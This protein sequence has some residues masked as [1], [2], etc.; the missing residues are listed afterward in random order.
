M[1]AS[2]TILKAVGAIVA[3]PLAF[4]W[5]KL[6]NAQNL[7]PGLTNPKYERP[8]KM[9]TWWWKPGDEWEFAAVFGKADERNFATPT[10]PVAHYC[11]WGEVLSDGDLRILELFFTPSVSRDSIILRDFGKLLRYTPESR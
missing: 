4:L 7:P 2:R 6:A 9:T 1:T 8:V 11:E 5:S 3:A 10:V